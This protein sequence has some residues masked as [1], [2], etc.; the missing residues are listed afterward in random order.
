MRR[1]NLQHYVSEALRCQE[2]D[3]LMSLFSFEASA[4][5]AISLKLKRI[6]HDL[7][8]IHSAIAPPGLGRVCCGLHDLVIACAEGQ[9]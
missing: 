1:V 2:V 4:G 7:G 5:S 8:L 3:D 9:V 6:L